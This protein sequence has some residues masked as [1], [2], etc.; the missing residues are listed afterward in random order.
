LGQALGVNH[1]LARHWPLSQS[2]R[3]NVEPWMA[4]VLLTLPD[5]PQFEA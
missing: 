3:L 4:R 1:V 2:V 5:P